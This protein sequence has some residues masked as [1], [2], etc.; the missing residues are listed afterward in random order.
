MDFAALSGFRLDGRV[1]A[2]APGYK[3]LP[4]VALHLSDL[5]AAPAGLATLDVAETRGLD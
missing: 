4:L 3:L 5:D 2:V 1:A